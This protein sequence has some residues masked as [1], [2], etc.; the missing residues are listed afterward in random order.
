V[1]V[2]KVC[3]LAGWGHLLVMMLTKTDHPRDSTRESFL[4][5]GHSLGKWNLNVHCHVPDSL[6]LIPVLSNR[7]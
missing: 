7:F 5:K 4:G 1:L 3:K 2:I 6:F